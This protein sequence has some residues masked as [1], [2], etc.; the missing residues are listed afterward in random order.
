MYSV[1][2]LG[3]KPPNATRERMNTM[4][5]TLSLILAL[6]MIMSLF[7][8][9]A[10]ADT[11]TVAD[12]VDSVGYTDT[13]TSKGEYAN[14]TVTI[15]H[16]GT[17][18]TLTADSFT[19]TAKSGYTAGEKSYASGKLTVAV[20]PDG[21]EA[22]NYD[23]AVVL[24]PI[25]VTVSSK[26]NA[27]A[28]WTASAD[29]KTFYFMH[30][31]SINAVA[32]DFTVT[33][34]ASG[35]TLTVENVNVSA[36]ITADIKVKDGMTFAAYNTGYSVVN[37][38]RIQSGFS[39]TSPGTKTVS[40]ALPSGY[41]GDYSSCAVSGA[42][43]TITYDHATNK[44]T[45]PAGVTPG[46]Y[47]ASLVFGGYTIYVP[48]TVTAL[49]VDLN[50]TIKND[51]RTQHYTALSLEA[52]IEAAVKNATGTAVEVT[53]IQLTALAPDGGISFQTTIAPSTT[54]AAAAA[55]QTLSAADGS[56]DALTVVTTAG[57]LGTA[58]LNFIASTAAHGTYNGS[59]TIKSDYAGTI[60]AAQTAPFYNEEFYMDAIGTVSLLGSKGA[61][62][63]L[64]SGATAVTSKSV[65]PASHTT[66]WTEE[67]TG[68][69]SSTNP[70]A[71]KVQVTFTPVAY[72]MVGYVEDGKTPFSASYFQNFANAVFA[73]QHPSY[74]SSYYSTYLDTVTIQDVKVANKYTLYYG[75]T[76]LTAGKALTPAQLESV[77]MD[78]IAGGAY[79]IDFTASYKYK[80]ASSSASTSYSTYPITGRVLVYAG[81]D[82]DI[83]YEVAYGEKVTF[84]SADFQ[85]LYRKL[86][87]NRYSLTHLTVNALPLSGGLYKSARVGNAYAVSVGDAFYVNANASYTNDMLDYLTY[88]AASAYTSEYSVYVPVTMYGT[89][90]SVSAVVE[91]VV[92]GNIPFYDISKNHTFYD[93]IRYAYN[94]GIMGGKSA[95]R[96][97][98]SSNITRAQLVTTLY[99]MAGSPATYNSRVLPFSDTKNLSVE[100]TNALKWATAKGI[101][102]GYGDKFNPNS[103]VT[104]QA[105]VTILYRYAKTA[106]YDVSVI[107]NNHLGYY[108]DGAK[109]SSGM[110]EAMNWA[111]DYGLVSGNGNRL[112]PAGST[113]R[114]AAAK[115]LSVFHENYVG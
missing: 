110:M 112:N 28:T 79:E 76:A 44:F 4:K 26:A 65:S 73:E 97:D 51:I 92:N 86:T 14:G 93:Y 23:I 115:I 85:A 46:T 83:K 67:Y 48:I 109:V 37:D 81:N 11:L 31:D 96:F 99:R 107:Y 16:L 84:D 105:M 10:F 94:H 70:V 101:V 30:K 24:K 72:D 90:T 35:Q 63:Y 89:G 18:P 62:S 102:N 9:A 100:F 41:T 27:S 87:N 106:G 12:V 47:T 20:T 69:Y 91:I 52:E 55:N 15:Y 13:A 39:I 34:R 36:A 7:T 64:T 2:I 25:T 42:G 66:S 71:Y 1:S 108:T 33:A 50:K 98:A 88:W 104:R 58:T 78:V 54:A 32:E 40:V 38:A 75:S 56:S 113:T 57:S 111:V 29:G 77:T 22:A 74:T 95:T 82:G 49:T 17:A 59:L 19:V 53:S 43:S 8:T 114:G 5:R 61:S 6:A 21:G 103:A 60:T 45:C 68:Y 3:E 80:A